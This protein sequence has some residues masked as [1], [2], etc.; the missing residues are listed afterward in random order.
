MSLFFTYWVVD[1]A[2]SSIMP[3]RPVIIGYYNYGHNK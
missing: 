1:G 3:T 2:K